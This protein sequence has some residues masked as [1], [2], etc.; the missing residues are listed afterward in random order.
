MVEQI[1]HF[2]QEI[3]RTFYHGAALQR[4]KNWD[5]TFEF[6]TKA[7]NE[8]S[9]KKKVVLFFDEFPWMATRKSGLLNSVDYY[10]NHHWSRDKRIKLIICGSSASWIV[11]N[12]INNKGGLHNRITRTIFLEPF[13][14]S[15]TKKF[16]EKN[17]IKLSNKHILNIFLLT[18][19]VP[20]YLKNVK[21]GMSSSQVVENLAFGKKTLLVNEFD[22]LFSSLFES[23]EISIEIV[24]II[25]QYQYGIGQEALFQQI[26]RGIKGKL[27]LRK[28][29]ELE[30]SG[31]IMSFKPYSHIKR[32]IYYKIID[33]YTLFYLRWI[34]PV[35]DAVSKNGLR[36]G[37]WEKQQASAAWKSWAGLAFES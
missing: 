6:L 7:I 26:D 2:T 9:K 18:G 4:K 19:G 13:N 12:I 37:Y 36:L 29:K 8:I 21:K 15:D 35:K 34:E 28:L 32:G 27:G 5:E 31:F 23:H 20:Y 16:L 30:D 22:N 1:G 17:G 14:L 25:A 24:R 10:W 33:E 3:G 11:D